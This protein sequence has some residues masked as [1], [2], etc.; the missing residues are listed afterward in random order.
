ML[1][2]SL[3]FLDFVLGRTELLWR[4]TCSQLLDHQFIVEAKTNW[5]V[6]AGTVVASQL[7]GTEV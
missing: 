6:A 3:S 2:P 5:V 1:I 7:V 4:A